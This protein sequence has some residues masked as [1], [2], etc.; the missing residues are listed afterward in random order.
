MLAI[1]TSQQGSFG[2]GNIE[3]NALT[4]E[5]KTPSWPGYLMLQRWSM[6]QDTT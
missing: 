3:R 4:L 6:P 5:E 2:P 1:Y